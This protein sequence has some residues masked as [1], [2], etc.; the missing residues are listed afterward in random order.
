MKKLS[1]GMPVYNGEKYIEKALTSLLNQS[2]N[3]WDLCI[4]DNN[5]IDNTR[6]ICEK[7]SKNDSR[8]SYIKQD[9]NLGAIENFIFLLEKS[10]SP[11]FMWAA[12]DD[13]W[14]KDFI[15]ACIVGLDS[16]ENIG[17]AFSNIV[18]IDSYGN[19]I[20]E[21]PSF[22]RFVNS[23]P[24]IRIISYLL[25]PEYMG[26]ANLIYG[27]FKQKS[28]KK[29][30][31]EFL[32]RRDKSEFGSDMALVLRILCDTNLYIDERIL[33]RK[34]LERNIDSK[35]SVKYIK[36]V[37]RPYVSGLLSKEQFSSYK[38]VIMESCQETSFAPLINYL[39]QYREKL[40]NQTNEEIT[41][42]KNGSYIQRKFFELI[43]R[44]IPQKNISLSK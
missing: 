25:D 9:Q 44:F 29:H 5:S 4:S 14:H 12:C 26:K 8:I 17:L 1:I 33:F 20:R 36:K 6:Y 40:N 2:Y 24:N 35:S 11:Y 15:E 31:L 42:L 22:K 30:L 32:S 28:I 23:D 37:E 13:I 21:Y 38:M 19:E 39:I 34:R 16:S 7:Y 41:I 18:N 3:E 27:I 43:K 10:V